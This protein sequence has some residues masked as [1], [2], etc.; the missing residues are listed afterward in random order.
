MSRLAALLLF[1]SAGCTA[2]AREAA[3]PP[4]VQE[5]RIT[6]EFAP[7]E[8][9]LPRERLQRWVDESAAMIR[10]TFAAFP[11]SELELTLV[12]RGSSRGI[13]DGTT[14]GANGRATIQVGV[15]GRAGESALERDWVL[16]HEMIHLAVPNLP[17]A[18]HWFE[19]GV[20]TY[21]EPF[22]RARGGKRS[23]EDVWRELT[24]DYA[25]GLPQPGE[26]GLDET[27]TW[28]STYYGGALFCLVADVEIGRA[29]QG[30][31]SLRDAFRGTVARGENILKES[32]L[33]RFSVEL[34]RVLGVDVVAPLYARWAHTAVP[35][36]LDALW[37]D[38]GVVREGRTV[39]FDDTAPL[40]R[41][42]ASLVHP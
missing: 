10:E 23:E 38:L 35:I 33:A 41:W 36:D 29:T 25:Q 16:V 8:L 14:R 21:L 28:A 31:R 18:Q 27:Q 32:D 40:A 15:G 9:A 39:R 1:A 37:K 34:D 42:R 5:P 17:P 12:P 20:A 26:H 19:E 3:D 7:G 30:K 4:P 24:R 11:V 2:G 6:V 22:A 13:H